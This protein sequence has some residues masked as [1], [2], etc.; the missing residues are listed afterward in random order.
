VHA[1]QPGEFEG[2][3]P[4]NENVPYVSRYL[5]EAQITDG[6]GNVLARLAYEDGEGVVTADIAPGRVEGELA[7]TPA[8]FWTVDLPANT[9][10]AWDHLNR[11]GRDYYAATFRPF[12]GGV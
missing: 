11:L 7:L 9:L 10:Q 6:H 8:G 12:L 1:A 4:G 3:T 2:L 5:G